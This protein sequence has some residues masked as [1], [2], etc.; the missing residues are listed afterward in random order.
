MKVLRTGGVFADCQI[1]HRGKKVIWYLVG[2]LAVCAV[3]FFVSPQLIALLGLVLAFRYFSTAYDAWEH[4]FLGKRGELRVT[5]ALN[6]L[7]DDYVLLNDLV[8]PKR[9]GNI[10]HFLIGPNGLFVI[11][12]KNFD[13]NVSCDGDRWFVNGKP[14][15]GLSSQAKSNAWAVR[16]NLQPVFNEHRAY[17]PFVEP[18]LVFVKH[19][20]RLDLN[21]PTVH[22]LKLEELV[23]FIYNYKP[24]SR[25]VRFSPELIQAIARHLKSLQKDGAN[26]VEN[27]AEPQREANPAQ[28]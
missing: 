13:S 15:K 9:R 10:D 25:S 11:E 7:P 19:K 20:R 23:D 22:V 16:E 27:S 6:A 2:F 4:W 24:R 8:L 3:F 17:L 1:R 12:T 18:L 21:Q 28:L 5:Q 26:I 14:T